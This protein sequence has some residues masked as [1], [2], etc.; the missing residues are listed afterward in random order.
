VAGRQALST[1]AAAWVAALR[2]ETANYQHALAAALTARQG[3][4]H[5]LRIATRRMLALVEFAAVLAPSGK[6]RA[7]QRE[8][9]RPFRKCARLR[10]LQAT[11]VHLRRMRAA[12]P[13][14]QIALLEMN[15]DVR[16]H[17][18]RTANQL[19]AVQSRKTCQKIMR[20]A[21]RGSVALPVGAAVNAC[22]DSSR[23]AVR[24]ARRRMANGGLRELHRARVAIKVCRYQLELAGAL[25][26][27][28]PVAELRTMRRLQKEFGA[29]TDLELLRRELKR[30]AR[31]HPG[32][33]CALAGI[34]RR[35][36]RE[37]GRRLGQALAAAGGDVIVC[38]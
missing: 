15:G 20:L 19:A 23:R 12:N 16:R 2:A 30:C 26:A 4:V 3:D 36:E 25:G 34:R 9:R 6:W 13:A 27:G 21:R 33:R 22:L 1:D 28:P 32:Q 18:R 35:I 29:I 17:R 5:E 10:D 24:A 7:L 37:R 11:R 14:L 31:R 38:A 8:L